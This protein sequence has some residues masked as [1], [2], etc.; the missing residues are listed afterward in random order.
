MLNWFKNRTREHAQRTNGTTGEIE[1]SRRR[2][3]RAAGAGA[4]AGGA[5]LVSGGAASAAAEIEPS[6]S[7]RETEHMKRYYDSARM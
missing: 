2:F 4:L 6:S 3:F 5:T 1:P 7:Y